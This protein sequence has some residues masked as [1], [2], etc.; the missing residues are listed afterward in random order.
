LLAKLVEG[1]IKSVKQLDELFATVLGY[2]CVKLI[3]VDED[4]RDLTLS[5]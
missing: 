5:V 2:D 3:N 1:V 4:D